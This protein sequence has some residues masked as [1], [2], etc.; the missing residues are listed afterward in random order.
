MADNNK[1]NS[2]EAFAAAAADR[3]I[4]NRADS[5][6]NDITDVLETVCFFIL[7][8]LMARFYIIDHAV[9]DGTSMVPTL[10]DEQ[11]LLY[12]KIYS[13]HDGDIVIV[14]NE[15][16]GPIV[17]RVIA[18]EGQQVD[19]QDG[20]VY[21]DGEL[22]NEQIY[23]EGDTLTADYFVSSPTNIGYNAFIPEENYPV[24]IPEGC[25]FI[26]GDNRRV[27]NDSRGKDVGFV[28]VDDVVGKVVMRYSPRDEF[29]IF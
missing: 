12:C 23:S 28:S 13:P 21:V 16:L 6:F 24:T 5:V 27:S 15:K 14:D 26:M 9:V 7:I 29:K 2:Y 1:D 18:T 19:I 3:K 10:E 17:K 25:I 20:C 4:K 8:F 22:L 11:K